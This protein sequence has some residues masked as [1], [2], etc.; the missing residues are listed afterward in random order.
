ML[1]IFNKIVS[2]FIYKENKGGVLEHFNNYETTRGA[3]YTNP[4]GFP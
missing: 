3:D 1:R 4:R 2:F